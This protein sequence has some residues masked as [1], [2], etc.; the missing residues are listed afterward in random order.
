MKE[1]PLTHFFQVDG[2]W[3]PVSLDVS[4][5]QTRLTLERP[6]YI[7][8]YSFGSTS[9]TRFPEDGDRFVIVP[10]PTSRLRRLL[11]RLAT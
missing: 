8:A 9:L 10:K 3:V 4:Q 7:D 2:D 11:L 6:R 5:S 1:K